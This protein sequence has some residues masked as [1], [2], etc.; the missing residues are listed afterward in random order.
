[1]DVALAVEHQTG[2]TWDL[3]K[4]ALEKGVGA[5][6]NVVMSPLSIATTLAMAGAGA[7]GETLKELSSVLKLPEGEAMHEFTAQ[8]QAAVLKDGSGVGGPFLSFVNGLWVD[9]SMTL[10]PKF[11]EQVKQSYGAEARTANFIQKADEERVAI[12]SWARDETKGRIEELLPANS[13]NQ[14]SRLVLA[15]ALYFKGKWAK[16]FD[17]V[18]TKN[19]DFH[20]LNGETVN[21]PFLTSVK[22]QYIRKFDTLKVLKLPYARGD[23][24]RSFSMYFVLPN[25][26]AGLT[27]VQKNLDVKSLTKD[28]R[29]ASREVKVGDF[30]LPKFKI[31]TGLTVPESLVKLGLEV[32]FSDK[33]DFTD[34]VEGPDAKQL[35]ISDVF[36]KSFIEVN[37]EGTEA[38]AASGAVMA[39]RSLAMPESPEDFVADHP[40]LFILREDVTGVILFIGRVTNPSLSE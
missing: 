38:A 33:A 36:H 16:Q 32:P 29:W 3:Y 37:E 12:N 17:A 39:L 9:K 24:Q 40:F 2:F 26:K 1:M 15:N 19:K 4:T 7:K 22:K 30:F 10:K 28:L 18:D 35:F 27:E 20:L 14:L 23:D 25:E 6:R 31:S 34:M 5:E 21:V 8:I 13:L 11:L